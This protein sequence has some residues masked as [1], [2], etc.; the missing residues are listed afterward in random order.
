MVLF[1]K[2]YEKT[3][4][5]LGNYK[6]G[7]TDR[8]LNYRMSDGKNDIILASAKAQLTEDY[9]ELS[10][11]TDSTSGVGIPRA[12]SVGPKYNYNNE[13]TLVLRFY[14]VADILPQNLKRMSSSDRLPLIK[15]VIDTCDIRFHSDDPS[16][17][18][19]GI[20]Q[21]LS[22]LSLS[23]YK[24]KGTKGDG[25]WKARHQAAGAGEIFIGKHLC[26]L[27]DEL[28]SFLPEIAKVIKVRGTKPAQRTRYKN[29]PIEKEAPIETESTNLEGDQNA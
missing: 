12:V 20:W 19:Q 13:Y 8:S 25:T 6:S 16:F 4:S 10:F 24:F 1:Q 23:I 18:W 17:Y 28:D 15:Q 22:K 7:I 11:I 5:E 2:I 27:L 14:K 3:I 21:Q 9:L 29:N 26:Q